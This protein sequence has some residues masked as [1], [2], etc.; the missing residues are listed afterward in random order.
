[1]QT[2]EYSPV[3]KVLITIKFYYIYAIWRP[4]ENFQ[5]KIASRDLQSYK[6]FFELILIV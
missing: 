4:K 2:I 5:F 1:M 6:I 3:L